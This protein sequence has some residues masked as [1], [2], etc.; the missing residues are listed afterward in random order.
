[1]SV[2]ASEGRLSCSITGLSVRCEASTLDPGTGDTVTIVV[3][4][5]DGSAP[6]PLTNTASVTTAT[7]DP[8]LT[9]NDSTVTVDVGVVSDLSI[10]KTVE[11]DPVPDGTTFVSA[12]A[13]EGCVVN[14][15]EG[16]VVV[17]CSLGPLAPGGIAS[18]TVTMTAPTST[19][20]LENIGSVGSGALDPC[21]DDGIC[22]LGD[23]LGNEDGISINVINR[24]P[25]AVD[26]LDL[27]AV[28]G[29]PLTIDV[30]ANDSDPDSEPIEV[31]AVTQPANGSAAIGSVIYTSTPGYTGPDSFTYTICD[32]LDQCDEALVTVQV[33][34]APA[35]PANP[36]PSPPP[37]PSVDPVSGRSAGAPS[38]RVA[39]TGLNTHRL[40]A[41]GL[42]LVLT[43]GSLRIV[44]R[45][46]TVPDR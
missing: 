17:T 3:E 15:Q 21:P 13:A 12:E 33:V 27:R 2:A 7:T 22:L 39:T 28:S 46:R 40:L 8:D 38:G 44:T 32:P 42:L 34:P 4:I 29:L 14:E 43:G 30:I 16:V 20:S 26:D 24:P 25:V 35:G 11:T 6:G 31:V 36:E 1:V 10:E 45:S 9:N 18:S 37:A 19:G 5:P 41:L 23:N